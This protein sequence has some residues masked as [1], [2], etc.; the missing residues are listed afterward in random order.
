MSNFDCRGCCSR[1]LRS[2]AYPSRFGSNKAFLLT[3]G[4][5]LPQGIQDQQARLEA[6]VQ[7]ALKK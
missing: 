2:A 7:A 4:E 5:R 3:L 1:R 6:R